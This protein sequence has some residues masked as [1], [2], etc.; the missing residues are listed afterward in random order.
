MPKQ[1]TKGEMIE[2]PRTM[3]LP[4]TYYPEFPPGTSMTHGVVGSTNGGGGWLSPRARMTW[5]AMLGA[6]PRARGV[7]PHRM[8]VSCMVIHVG[9]CTK[10]GGEEGGSGGRTH[11]SLASC[12]L[13]IDH[14]SLWRRITVPTPNRDASNILA[15]NTLLPYTA[16]KK[17]MYILS[18]SSEIG[19][20]KRE[21]GGGV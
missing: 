10:S 17:I 7:C 19:C 8:R 15:L 9:L 12:H 21:R 2:T 13:D 11:L 18:P 5:L 16:L 20:T 3:R 4:N 1:R 6:E 14:A